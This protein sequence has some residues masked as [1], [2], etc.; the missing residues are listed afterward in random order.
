MSRTSTRPAGGCLRGDGYVVVTKDY[1]Q[2]M[3]HVRIAEC[4]LGKPLPATARVHHVDEDR[5][6]N[7]P[8]NLV[9]CPNEA[10]HQLLHQRMRA[11]A[12][13]GH[14]DWRICSFCQQYD[15]PQALYIRPSNKQ[16][17]HPACRN[18]HDRARRNQK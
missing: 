15:A 18:A 4:A 11:Y 14:H 2:Q 7:V 3:E 10:Y 6:N 12:A 9:I 17:W 5:S 16:A 8:A 1:V 13:C